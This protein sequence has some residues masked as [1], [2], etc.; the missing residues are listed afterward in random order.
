MRQLARRENSPAPVSKDGWATIR[1]LLPYLWEYKVRVI[2]ALTFLIGAKVGNVTVPIIMK[3]IVDNLGIVLSSPE[4][5][6]FGAITGLLLAYG[7]ARL[8]TT[9]FTE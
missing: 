2:L 7:V 9:V 4:K 5:L 1:T 3:H 6:A 8:S